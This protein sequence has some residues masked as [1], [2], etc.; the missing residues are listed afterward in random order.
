MKN[1]I[2][3]IFFFLAFFLLVNCSFGDKAG[4]WS[5]VENEEKQAFELQKEQKQLRER[6]K[7]YSKKEKFSKEVISNKTITLNPPKNKDKIY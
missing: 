2:K 7:I 3:Y 1:K 4:I 6:I 5:G